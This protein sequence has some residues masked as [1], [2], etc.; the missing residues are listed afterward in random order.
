VSQ[1]VRGTWHYFK[2]AAD[3]QPPGAANYVRLVTEQGHSEARERY[4]VVVNQRIDAGREC[5]KVAVN[6]LKRLDFDAARASLA[7]R[8]IHWGSN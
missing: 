6:A 1:D 8:W 2:L 5:V 7:G 4:P 3:R